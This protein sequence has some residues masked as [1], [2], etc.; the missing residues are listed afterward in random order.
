M[1]ERIRDNLLVLSLG[2]KSLAR[3]LKSYT[4]CTKKDEMDQFYYNHFNGLFDSR[5]YVFYHLEYMQD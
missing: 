5:D 4:W 2:Q 3:V 1:I